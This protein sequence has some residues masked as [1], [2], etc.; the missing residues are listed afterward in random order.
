MKREG[1]T[2]V[3]DPQSTT[4]PHE[5]HGLRRQDSDPAFGPVT[6]AMLKESSTVF[7]LTPTDRPQAL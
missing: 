5:A 6:D 4:T 7:L 1:Q 2:T 3:S